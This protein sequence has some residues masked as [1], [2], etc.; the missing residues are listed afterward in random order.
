MTVIEVYPTHNLI[1]AAHA[2]TAKHMEGYDPSHDILHVDRVVQSALTIAARNPFPS[3]LIPP[4]PLVVRLSALFHDLNDAKYI[5]DNS[6]GGIR[7][8][9]EPFWEEHD[10]ECIVITLEQRER[11]A[12]VVDNVSWS[13]AQKRKLA[14]NQSKATKEQQEEQEFIDECTELHCVSDADR[15]DAIGAFG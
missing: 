5:K 10:P 3:H 2:F 6:K 9:L 11:I 7:Q 1:Q 15:L 4:D 8:V 12:R 13:K 14:K